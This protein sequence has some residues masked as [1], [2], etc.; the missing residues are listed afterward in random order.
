[1]FVFPSL[2]YKSGL[3]GIGGSAQ[4]EPTFSGLSVEINYQGTTTES[5]YGR[6]DDNDDL[7]SSR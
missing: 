7:S 6:S 2:V 3:M 4:G 5:S 1:M